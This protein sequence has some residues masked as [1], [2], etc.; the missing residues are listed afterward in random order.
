M[1]KPKFKPSYLNTIA[2]CITKM[3][4]T[5]DWIHQ[6]FSSTEYTWSFFFFSFLSFFGTNCWILL[7]C[8]T[9]VFGLSTAETKTY[10][11]KCKYLMW[12]TKLGGLQN[13]FPKKLHNYYRSNR[14]RLY[15]VL[16]WPD[17]NSQRLLQLSSFFFW[18][19]WEGKERGSS[20]WGLQHSLYFFFQGKKK[21]NIEA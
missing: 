18:L 13:N 9:H 20:F 3:N 15:K 17:G 12:M 2:S 16:I 7:P 4:E 10:E 8:T 1:Q 21:Q 19:I 14:R 11:P 6:A 5:F